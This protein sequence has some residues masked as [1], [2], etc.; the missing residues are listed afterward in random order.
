MHGRPGVYSARYAGEP[1]DDV[2]NYEKVLKEMEHVNDDERSARFICVLALAIP[3]QETIYKEG[4]CEGRIAKQTSGL[5]GFGY[6]PIF[7]P[8][9]YDVTMAQLDESEKNAIS[10]RSDAL[11]KMQEWLIHYF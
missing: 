9:G 2:K 1:T 8:E 10:H 3:E 11:Q 5:H 6:D 4:Y 7:I